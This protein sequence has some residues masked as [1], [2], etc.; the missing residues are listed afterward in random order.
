MDDGGIKGVLQWVVVYAVLTRCLIAFVARVGGEKG[1]PREP[2]L[3]RC[4]EEADDIFPPVD[5]C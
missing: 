5:E 2:H 1:V 4:Y 3:R